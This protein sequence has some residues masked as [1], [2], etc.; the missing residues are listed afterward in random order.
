MSPENRD[1]MLPEYDMRGGARGKF[2]AHAQRWKGITTATGAVEVR[3]STTA[4]ESSGAKI[5]LIVSHHATHISPI[6]PQTELAQRPRVPLEVSAR[7]H[8]R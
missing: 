2:F 3:G 8:A 7:V 1:E 6:S 4:S 5:V